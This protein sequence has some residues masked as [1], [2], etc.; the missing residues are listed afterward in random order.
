MRTERMSGWV[1]RSAVLVWWASVLA[2]MLKHRIYVSH[3]TLISYAHVWYISDRLWHG[4]GLPYR[5]PLLHHGQAVAFPYGLVPWTT[6]AL[7]RPL[8]GDWVVT[9]WLVLGTVGLMASTFWAFPELRRG[10]WAAAA[11][12]N[13]ALVS[14]PVI[15]QLPFVW[16]AMLLLV[17]VGAWRRGRRTLATVAAALA[18]VTHPAIAFPLTAAVV[19]ARLWWEPERRALVRH[20]AWT[21]PFV[22][23]TIAMTLASPVFEDTPVATQ[24]TTFVGTIAPRCLIVVIPIALVVVRRVR[25]PA[26]GAAAAVLLVVANMVVG[27]RLGMPWAWGALERTPDR[28]MLQFTS[29][30]AFTPGATYRILRIADGKVGMYQVLRAGGRL[31]SEFFPESI[32]RNSWPDTASYSRFLRHRGV[33]AVMLWRGYDRRYATNEHALLNELVDAARCDKNTVEVHLGQRAQNYDVYR[34]RTA[35]S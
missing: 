12:V 26:T 13:P 35:C 2:R 10:W 1:A 14:S 23:V 32:A 17:A 11:L 25:W 18:Q 15:G 31:D 33:D 24:L 21:L 19:L 16:A 3:D 22:G 27:P 28:R 30:K 5:M 6:A 29:S 9:L 20:Y 34:V 8:L 7:V 4:H